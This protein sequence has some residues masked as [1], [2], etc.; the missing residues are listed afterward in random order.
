MAIRGSSHF[1]MAGHFLVLTLCFVFLPAGYNAKGANTSDSE[2]GEKL[3]IPTDV[4]RDNNIIQIRWTSDNTD[5]K[6]YKVFHGTDGTNYPNNPC[7]ISPPFQP[8]PSTAGVRIGYCCYD[9]PSG[10]THYFKVTEEYNSGAPSSVESGPFTHRNASDI[11]SVKLYKYDNKVFTPYQHSYVSETLSLCQTQS[12]NGIIVA[13]HSDS[14]SEQVYE[15]N[16]P[17]LVDIRGVYVCVYGKRLS[18]TTDPLKVNL[19][20]PTPKTD[21]L[22]L[23]LPDS[24]FQW[25]CVMFE[26]DNNNWPANLSDVFIGF[27]T[28]NIPTGGGFEID[29]VYLLFFK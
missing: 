6:A 19:L 10:G 21:S 20:N 3:T 23:E 11:E 15:V 4:Y 5:V 13:H 17:N 14:N 24:G 12:P 18:A 22:I 29:V 8:H 16:S 2:R 27:E 26:E 28:G 1:R 9:P 7:N 25:R